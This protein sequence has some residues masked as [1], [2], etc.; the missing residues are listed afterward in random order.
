MPPAP[1]YG[2]HL[3][4]SYDRLRRLYAVLGRRFVLALMTIEHLLQ[5]FVYGGGGGGFVGVPI[6]FLLRQYGLTASR[7]QVLKTIAVSPWALKPLFGVVSDSLYWGGYNRVPYML[8]TTLMACGACVALVVAWPVGPTGAT[9]LFFLLFLQIAVADLLL[10]ASYVEKTQRHPDVAPDLASFNSIFSCAFQLAS[11]LAVGLC[12]KY[13]PQLHYIYLVPLPFLVV[14][15]WPMYN[16]WVDDREYVY[17]ERFLL[18]AESSTTEVSVEAS[19][20]E[21]LRVTRSHNALHN[22]CCGLGWYARHQDATL[23]EEAPLVPL[24][25]LDTEKLRANWRVFLLALIIASISLLTSV[26]GLAELSTTTLFVLSLVGA[27]LMIG[28]FFALVDHRIAR[29]QSFVIVQNMFGLSL[30]AA[31]FFFYTDTAEQYPQG[32]HF[33]PFFYVTVM[34]ALATLVALLGAVTYQMFMTRWRY[35]KVLAVTNLLYIGVSAFNLIFFLRWNV[36]MGVPDWLFVLGAE[37]LQVITAVWSSLPF[38]VM[39]LQ[40]CPPGMEATMY[41]LLAGSS[42]LGSALA[43]YQGAFVLDQLGIRP[44]GAAGEGAQFD[45]MW[46]A[47]LINTLLPLVPLLAIP[48]LIPNAAQTDSLLDE[49]VEAVAQDFEE[50]VEMQTFCGDGSVVRHASD[51]AEETSESGGAMI[52]T[53]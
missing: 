11:V 38:S 50:M 34:G 12:V 1:W 41:A 44:T 35:W 29:I 40:L 39:M 16:N 52:E 15:L 26:V 27:P 24:V 14:A 46:I 20:T 45:N 7:I 33:S 2:V 53:K 36:A 48:L 23:Y 30:D 43:Q 21:E 9:L 5:A 6:Q 49:A 22:V 51:D 25:G 8:T 18:D 4:D 13:M 31:T 3:R 28:C 42:N 17:R 10:E 47:V 32:P 19:D 37:G